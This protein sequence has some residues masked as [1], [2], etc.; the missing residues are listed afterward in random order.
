MP[1]QRR[2]AKVGLREEHLGQWVRSILTKARVGSSTLQGDQLLAVLNLMSRFPQKHETYGKQLRISD[3]ERMRLVIDFRQTHQGRFP[4]VFGN[5][6]DP[7]E[8]LAGH[9]L[10]KLRTRYRGS[11]RNEREQLD[12]VVLEKLNVY[13]P[14]WATPNIDKPKRRVRRYRRPEHAAL[15]ALNRVDALVCPRSTW[16]TMRT[17]TST[18]AS[19]TSSHAAA[20]SRADFATPRQVVADPVATIARPAGPG[21]VSCGMRIVHHPSVS[22]LVNAFRVRALMAWAPLRSS[23]SVPR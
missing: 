4:R 16:T 8:R 7:V 1:L 22:M 17:F 12:P 11:R 18:S 20:S 23:S 6:E 21:E 19:S 14:G 5:E 3:H 10:T 15:L 2:C 13:C 9:A